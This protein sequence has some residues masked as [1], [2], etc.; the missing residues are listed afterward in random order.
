MNKLTTDY[1]N[2]LDR[3]YNLRGSDSV[4]LKDIDDHVTFATSVYDETE[5]TRVDFQNNISRLKDEVE[6]LSSEGERLRI[7][8]GDIHENDFSHVLDVL[9]IDFHPDV[10]KEK[11]N[12]L[13]PV[14]VNGL[15]ND[16]KMSSNEL[17]RVNEKLS[18][19]RAEI[20]ELNIKKEEAVVNQN[21][22]NHFFDLALNGNINTTREEL[23]ELFK[24]LLFS[25]EESRE[26]AKLL[27][28]PE[29]GL[30]EYERDY[31]YTINERLNGNSDDTVVEETFEDKDNVSD[32]SF[33][34]AD[35][36]LNGDSLNN[37]V[38]DN[39]TEP[40]VVSNPIEVDILEDSTISQQPAEETEA[41]SIEVAPVEPLKPAFE[42][43]VNAEPLNIVAPEEVAT[44]P[45][46]DNTEVIS[47]LTSIGFDQLDFAE[48]DILKISKNFDKETITNN[49]SFV[50]QI[51]INLD[52]FVDNIE[53]LYDKEMSEKINK[54]TSIGK[55]PQDIYLNPS[56]LTKYSLV[57]LNSAIQTLESSGLEPKN[58]PLMAY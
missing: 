13:L 3:I 51:G 46:T 15:T 12:A 43:E 42:D 39:Y 7:V 17:S 41:T 16:I 21:R 25:D 10:A 24:S 20:E 55:L 23:T 18:E 37:V 36:I 44:T 49:V 26:A 8:L 1:I 52:V 2:L 27:M 34:T 5:K 14:A 32:I 19:T 33:I 45:E 54:L 53:L 9:K 47:F 28:F 30:Y 58:V 48:N 11:L 29:D 35:D 6:Q 22:L 57:E 40:S 56:V 4:I 50:K 31:K 38:E